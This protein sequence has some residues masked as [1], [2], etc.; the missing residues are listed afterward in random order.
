MPKGRDDNKDRLIIEPKALDRL[1]ERNQVLCRPIQDVWIVEGLFEVGEIHQLSGPSGVGKTTWMN[2][3]MYDWALGKPIL[4]HKS[5]PRPYAYIVCDRSFNLTTM[6]LARLGLQ[7]WNVP[8][9][10]IDELRR[11]IKG[12]VTIPKI[13]DMLPW[14][15]VFFIE[16][17]GIFEPTSNG[18]AAGYVEAMN[19]WASIR[20]VLSKGKTIIATNH[21]PKAKGKERYGH[22][23]ERILGSVAH[24]ASIA[25]TICFDFEEENNSTDMNR[26]LTISPRNSPNMVLRYGLGANGEFV[27]KSVFEGEE[28]EAEKGIYMLEKELMNIPKGTFITMDTVKGWMDRTEV[29]KSQMYN[30]INKLEARKVIL[31]IRKGMYRMENPPQPGSL[32]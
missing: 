20:Q 18:K 12:E 4:G 29:G 19:Y 16:A 26:I 11:E 14:V 31:R 15:E 1:S 13:V 30:I 25:T 10:T 6:T 24:G 2:A 28:K 17:I 32:Q 21:S 22:S 8:M 7:D 9:F 27:Y 23:R 5:Y 3:M